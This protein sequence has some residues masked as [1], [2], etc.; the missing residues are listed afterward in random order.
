MKQ[1][2]KHQR[3]FETQQ[4]RQENVALDKSIDGENARLRRLID[5]YEL[6]NRWESIQRKVR[7]AEY[8]KSLNPFRMS[9]K[10]S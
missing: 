4:I 9:S 7:V 6:N 10:Q 2:R 3:D 8:L 1:D 5:N